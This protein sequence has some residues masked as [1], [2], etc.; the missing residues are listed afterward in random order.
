MTRP[1][2]I[3]TL[4]GSD[5]RLH[6][7]WPLLPV[8]VAVY[9]WATLPWRE[10][11][12]A[13]L[14]LLATYICVLSREGVQ[15][16]AARRFGLGTRDVTLYPFWGVAR[17]T[18]L[19]D[20]PWQENYI[21][22]TGPVVLALI[23]T[24]LAGVLTAAGQSLAFPEP[25]AGFGMGVFLVHLFWANVFLL[26]LHCLPVLPLDAG[27]I[28]RASVAMRTSR[29]RATEIAA[30]L[31]T[32]GAGLMLV[33]AIVWLKS[34]LLGVTAV[35]LYLGAQ[36][37]LGTT[38]YFASLRHASG[39]RPNPPAVLVPMDQIVSLDCRPDEPNFTGFT[40][41]AHARLWIEWRDGQPVS[42]NALI[43]DGRP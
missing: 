28:V 16:L 37:D 4:H 8:G 15:L 39:D 9:S 10:A 34:P 32:L 43:G 36:E 26:G 41:N 19:S 6:W 23:A 2:S 38:R 24:A 40:W 17:L 21:A 30:G 35:L 12:F 20:R 7:S 25:L 27:R 3:G 29:L 14:L 11:V 18:R 31:S 5:L 42:A 13:V 22:A 33:T 1:L